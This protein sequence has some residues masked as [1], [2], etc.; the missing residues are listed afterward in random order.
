MRE[1]EIESNII[2]NKKLDLIR[3]RA[4]DFIRKNIGKI[5]EKDVSRFIVSEIKKE[6]MILDKI[7]PIHF[8]VTNENTDDNHWNKKIWNFKVINE[9]CLIMIDYW[10]KLKGA[11]NVFAD[12]TW[13]FY[14]GNK[15]PKEIENTFNKVINARNLAVSFI[16]ENLK[17]G[18]FPKA[19]DIDKTVRDYFAKFNLERFFTHKTG[20][21]LG[22]S[23]CHGSKFFISKNS[24]K[25]IGQ[26]I[27]FTIEPGL[28]FSRKFGIRSEIN[29]YINKDNKLIITS[30]VQ[31]KIVKIKI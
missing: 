19:K 7:N 21:A 15:I 30:S 9:N 1:K 16:K 26:N 24:R 12:I 13:M 28:Y 20:H 6:G 10:A 29:C 4:I 14:V 25:T 27:L 3:D 22:Y 17:I 11:K 18:I 31:D 5:K 8:V 2:A 23:S